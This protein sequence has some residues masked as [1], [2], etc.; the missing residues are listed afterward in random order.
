MVAH[1]LQTNN[2]ETGIFLTLGNVELAFEIFNEGSSEETYNF[3]FYDDQNWFNVQSGSTT[4]GPEE[5]T[6]IS[7]IGSVSEISGA[8]PLTLMVIPFH[9]PELGRTINLNAYSGALVVDSDPVPNEYSLFSPFPN[10][11]N[12]SVLIQ[13]SAGNGPL[14]LEIR[15]ISGRHIKTLLEQN[16]GS[17]LHQIEWNAN[18]HP[19]GLYFIRLETGDQIDIKKIIYLK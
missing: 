14:I 13:F 5:H 16:S 2:G 19:S 15:D 3:E 6:T 11:F 12:S 4:L 17:G 8:N 9:R 7:F 1:D 18:D 10:P